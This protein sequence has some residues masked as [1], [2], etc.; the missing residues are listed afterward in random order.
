LRACSRRVSWVREGVER[1]VVPHFMIATAVQV[2]L[3]PVGRRSNPLA[4]SERGAGRA[5]C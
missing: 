3:Q 4:G 2:S 5:E 1:S